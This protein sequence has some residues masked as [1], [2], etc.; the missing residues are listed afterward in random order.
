MLDTTISYIAI[1]W[2]FGSSPR[3]TLFELI[4]HS[5]AIAE[6]ILLNQS[7]ASFAAT[8]LLATAGFAL[9]FDSFMT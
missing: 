1:K 8:S 2:I 3:M 7:A 6:I 5:R 4:G 9:P